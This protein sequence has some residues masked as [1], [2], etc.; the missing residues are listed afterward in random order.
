[1]INIIIIIMMIE[2]IHTFQC[3]EQ[4]FSDTFF[5]NQ[6]LLVAI[7]TFSFNYFHIDTPLSAGILIFS[8]SRSIFHDH[9]RYYHSLLQLININIYLSQKIKMIINMIMMYILE[10]LKKRRTCTADFNVKLL[11][12]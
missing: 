8:I 3:A 6:N 11:R 1:M 10:F 5:L 7:C 4:Y 12:A 9:S 2:L